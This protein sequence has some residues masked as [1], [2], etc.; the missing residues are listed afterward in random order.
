[1]IYSENINR[2][3]NIVDAARRHA[4]TRWPGAEFHVI[5]WDKRFQLQ[6]LRPEWALVER[7]FRMHLIS[8][9]LP[10]Y[11]GNEL[12]YQQSKGDSHPNAVAFEI[13]ADHVVR[14]VLAGRGG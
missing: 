2:F 4:E 5:Y 13:L 10:G 12:R 7:G 6:T 9:I 8:E 3:V 1:M 14:L 11:F